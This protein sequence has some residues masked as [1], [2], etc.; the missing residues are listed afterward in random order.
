MG[1]GCQLPPV[2]PSLPQYARMY[3]EKFPS[4]AG[5]QFDCL[6]APGDFAPTYTVSD[7]SS[8]R[9]WTAR[10]QFTATSPVQ[11]QTLRPARSSALVTR[12]RFLPHAQLT[13]RRKRYGRSP[14]KPSS[15]PETGDLTQP[16]CGGGH[17]IFGIGP[18]TD[19]MRRMRCDP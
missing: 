15:G 5:S 17:E 8:L 3:S 11:R 16:E 1:G 9:L 4:G 2:M 18:V 12:R 6:P 13:T 19:A 10:S 7:P 14:P